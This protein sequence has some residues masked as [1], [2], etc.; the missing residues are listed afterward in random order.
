MISK[1]NSDTPAG[2]QTVPSAQAMGTDQWPEAH[3]WKEV[4]IHFC[5]NQYSQSGKRRGCTSSIRLRCDRARP[6][7]RWRLVGGV[8]VGG[9]DGC[10]KEEGCCDHEEDGEFVV[11]MWMLGGGGEEE[12]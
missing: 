1:L 11:S 10:E 5:V 4:I 3:R 6:G 2:A 7:G 8:G 12:V 9:G